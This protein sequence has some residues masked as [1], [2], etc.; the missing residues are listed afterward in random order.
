MPIEVGLKG[1]SERI[2]TPEMTA[3]AAG[4]GAQEVLATPVMVGMMENAALTSLQPYLEQ[5]QS[6]VG[7]RISV[8]HI[9]A[10]PVGMRVRAESEVTEIDRKRIVFAVRAFD[11]AGLVGEGT[12][13]RFII[14]AEKFMAKCQ[15]KKA[16]KV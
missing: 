9:S 3:A 11:E 16:A 10:T 2:V 1:T 14:D 8:S 5:G 13:E 4:S 15:A 7:T 6:S 12:H